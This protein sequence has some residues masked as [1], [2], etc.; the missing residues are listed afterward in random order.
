M[1]S[2]LATKALAKVASEAGGEYM[3][4]KEEDKPGE[5]MEHRI[6]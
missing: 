4:T 1:L 2:A 6:N 5:F 3:E